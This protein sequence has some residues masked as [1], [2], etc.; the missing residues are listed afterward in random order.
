MIV[1]Y[2]AT[3]NLGRMPSKS[4]RITCPATQMSFLEVEKGHSSFATLLGLHNIS[5]GLCE[6]AADLSEWGWCQCSCFPSFF[7][8][9]GDFPPSCRSASIAH[10]TQSISLLLITLPLLLLRTS[11]LQASIPESA[12]TT[13]AMLKRNG[14]PM[15]QAASPKR[16]C[17]D[18]EATVEKSSN[19]VCPDKRPQPPQLPSKAQYFCKTCQ[20]FD[21]ATLLTRESKATRIG[22]LRTFNDPLC[23]LC[24]T[25]R[26]F[27]KL[28]WGHESPSAV[29]GRHPSVHM[30]SKKWCY[31]LDFP[32]QK[33]HVYRII[34]AL[35]QRPPNLRLMRPT[36][37]Y[38]NKAK[39]ILT[40][41]EVDPMKIDDSGTVTSWRRPILSCVDLA[42]VQ[43]WLNNCRDHYLC[44][45]NRAAQQANMAQTFYTSGFRLIDVVE[46][47]LVEKTEPCEYIALSYV[48]GSAA[49]FGLC[50]NKEN[51]STLH[52]PSS[53][54]RS[55]TQHGV[56]KRL[57][58]TIADAI[59]LSR[60]IGQ[61]YLWVDSLCIVQNDPDEK[62]R[63]IHGMNSVYENADL[64]LVALSGV[65]A[66]AGLAGIS[67]RGPDT[68]NCGREHLFHEINGTFSIGTGRISLMEQIQCSHWNS[69]GWTYQE[70]LLSPRK[71]Y[72]ASGEVFYECAYQLLREG[73]AFETLNVRA[74]LG[75]P[76]YGRNLNM[77]PLH[78]AQPENT[79]SMIQNPAALEDIHPHWQWPDVEFQKIVSV[80]TRRD[81]KESGDILHALTG[82]YNRF[83]PSS[84]RDGLGISALQGGIPMRCFSR[85]LLWFTPNP[86]H[87]RRTDVSGASPSTWSWVSWITPVDFACSARPNF[88]TTERELSHEAWNPFSLVKEWCLT[89]QTE[90]TVTK[91]RFLGRNFDGEDLTNPRGANTRAMEFL[92]IFPRMECS[93]AGV[94][95]PPLVPGMLDFLGLYIPV[96]KAA[97]CPRWS[98]GLERE[99]HLNFEGTPS[100]ANDLGC[101]AIV[102]FDCE[103]T[104]DA[105]VLL[106]YDGTCLGIC[107]KKRGDYFERVGICIFTTH[108]AD[109]A[110]LMHRDLLEIYWKRILLR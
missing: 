8:G 32:W 18:L 21:L 73:Y 57:P 64:T 51:L 28:H 24:D 68:D 110:F 63:L 3:K 77:D 2:Y 67:P 7:V 27:V 40:E 12:N 39:F 43:N 71:L 97:A 96:P 9:R 90:K 20:K 75:A 84:D 47:R 59:S 17:H 78:D 65:D 69:R 61:R 87:T 11:S 101:Y 38:D 86:C 35:D 99:W 107:V 56:S 74:R 34:L 70:Q 106:L 41:L 80:Y 4:M 98:K 100:L 30:Q 42:L 58:K 23:Q 15:L 14:D 81:L 94:L 60:L 62:R 82:V 33:K 92:N 22:S 85:T 66:D 10:T 72:F 45:N 53:L 79:L 93:V 44:K 102:L 37:P 91:Q 104:M 52:Q 95:S 13:D 54:D 26:H 48:W 29:N 36:M 105:F 108:E 16:H 83:Y 6:M 49:S 31:F 19:Q 76:W 5:K 55:H 46:G 103:E 88:P 1:L 89:I 50:T 25:I 109:W